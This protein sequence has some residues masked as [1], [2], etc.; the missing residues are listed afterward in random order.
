MVTNS[1]IDDQISLDRPLCVDLDGTLIKTD[2]LYE[3][4]VLLV[5]Q[6]PLNVL[7]LVF[8]LFKGK[9][10]LKAR[11]AE[12]VMPSADKLPY[13][14]AVLDWLND[15][16]ERGRSLIL[17]TASHKSYATAVAKHLG[18]FEQVEASCET[19]N[20][21]S[22]RKADRLIESFGEGGFDYV[23]N[24]KD[25]VKVW[26]KARTA[27]IVGKERAAQL[28]LQND[29]AFQI[30]ETEPA[31][32]RWKVWAKAIRIHQWLKNSLLFVPAILASQYFEF[33][34][35]VNLTIAFLSFGLCASSV[36]LLNDMVD[37]E[38]DRRH[39]TKKNR[40]LA[41]GE[42]G[43][44]QAGCVSLGMLVAGLALSL[45][46]PALFTLVLLLYFIIT[47][48]YSFVLKRLLLLDVLTLAGLFTIRVIAGATAVEGQVSTWLLAF[49]M[50]F[51]LSLALVKRFVE[52]TTAEAE[53]NR[54]K[55]GRGYQTVDLETLG[56]GGVASGFAAV[57]VLALFIDSPEVA[58][59]YKYPQM[60]WLVCPLVLYIVF[61]IWILARRKE[62][63]DDPVV[64]LITDWRSQIM[65]VAGAVI[66]LT[67]QL[68]SS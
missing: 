52:I 42:I 36:Y 60:I 38:V 11:I 43:M 18:L 46:L 21:S 32:P 33:S 47:C 7:L 48:A 65:I 20:L 4:V 44:L 9:A 35:F 31:R 10:F 22:T 58:E 19:T 59:T 5:R 63:H 14:Q 29:N 13:N 45:A 27:F 3:A 62:M 34:T 56:Q 25:D 40:P 2:M 41:S 30:V 12:K 15:Q 50:F 55:T 51:F 61:R 64:F 66:M 17:A 23:G 6:N 1:K 26:D 54:A 8:W 53:V 49:C 57:V 28:Y 16:K 68:L 39:P 67:S 24:S 37:V